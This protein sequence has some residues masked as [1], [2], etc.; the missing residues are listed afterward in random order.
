MMKKKAPKKAENKKVNPDAYTANM[1]MTL[2]EAIF[3]FQVLPRIPQVMEQKMG[4]KIT[5]KL[6]DFIMTAKRKSQGGKT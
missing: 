2:S 1:T 6:D 4:R 5:D 3:L